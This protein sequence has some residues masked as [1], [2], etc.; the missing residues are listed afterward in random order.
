MRRLFV[1]R[2]EPGAGET[3]RRARAAGLDAVAAPLFRI[4]PVGWDVP[5]GAFDALLLTSANA[6]RHGGPGLEQLQGLPVHAVGEA[7]AAAARAA[8]FEIAGIGEAGVDRLLASLARGLRLLHLTGEDRRAPTAPQQAITAVAVYRAVALQPDLGDIGGTVAAVHSPRAARRLSEL[9][10]RGVRG[11][12]R[13]AAISTAAAQA[14]G[15]GWERV[16]AADAP[17]DAALLALA[18]RLC[19]KHG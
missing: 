13:I 19:E 1:L 17:S 5:A 15:A 12:V 9:V 6:V 2:P 3:V 18:A 14:A 11:S 7:T 8:G 4:E 10:A 16:E